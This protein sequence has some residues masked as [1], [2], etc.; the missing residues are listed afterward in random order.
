MPLNILCI[1][2]VESY[3]TIEKPLD[4]GNI[5]PFGISLI[6]SVLQKEGHVIKYLVITPDTPLSRFLNPI[7]ESF[8]P[9]IACLTAVTTQFPLVNRIAEE[10]KHID[11]HIFVVMGGPYTSLMPEKAI[12]SPFLDAICISEGERAAVELAAQIEQGFSPT[13]I[14]N[15]W[16]KR[17]DVSGQEIIEKNKV[18]PFISDLDRLP[19]IDRDLLR[20]WIDQ[21][22]KNPAVLVGRGC[23]FSCTYCSNHKLRKLAKGR[24]VRYRSP[25]NIVREIEQITQNPAVTN[26]YLEVETIGSNTEYALQLCQALKE[27]NLQRQRPIIFNINLAITSRFI[28]D[29]S[30]VNQLLRAFQEANIKYINV[31]IESGSE[32]IRNEVLRRPRYTNSEVICFCGMA[33]TYDIKVNLFVLM[34]LPSE[35]INDFQKTLDVVKRCRPEWVFLS[36]YYPY[37]GTDLYKLA[38]ENKL[39]DEQTISHVAERQRVY[40]NLPEFSPRR[41]LLEYILFD[42][43]IFKGRWPFLHRVLHT[44]KKAM[45][46]TTTTKKW[47]FYLSRNSKL[48]HIFYER[49]EHK[50]R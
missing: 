24:Y 23:P 46:M 13:G 39:F 17:R 11:P 35:T 42:F 6:A 41:I 19:F 38:K 25:N 18:A 3:I 10:I 22:D 40:I 2:T 50:F 47:Y 30:S 8:Q 31:G 37:P 7:I 29:V 16:I 36:I 33:M 28:N 1:Y 34:G 5:I 9:K 45:L 32:R 44:I 43:K 15:L 12:D 49:Y 48:G 4:S 21:P 20:P 26:I 27:F 14:D